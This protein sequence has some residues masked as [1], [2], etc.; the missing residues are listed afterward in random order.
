MKFIWINQTNFPI[1]SAWADSVNT[2]DFSKAKKAI[3]IELEILKSLLTKYDELEQRI[4]RLEIIIN[5]VD[6]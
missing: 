6:G 4:K 2:Y 5:Q 3:E 1:N